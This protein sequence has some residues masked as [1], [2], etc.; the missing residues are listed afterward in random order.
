MKVP[1]QEFI[2]ANAPAIEAIRTESERILTNSIDPMVAER[3]GLAGE[4]VIVAGAYG[5]GDFL[6]RYPHLPD[7]EAQDVAEYVANSRNKV[8]R[9]RAFVKSNGLVARASMDHTI[10]LYEAGL[11]SP[12]DAA[13]REFLD[14]EKSTY[15]LV[16]MLVDDESKVMELGHAQLEGLE[17]YDSADDYDIELTDE[18]GLS[19]QLSIARLGLTVVSVTMD[20]KPQD[21]P[22]ITRCAELLGPGIADIQPL[23]VGRH[24]SAEELDA[25]ISEVWLDYQGTS[26]EQEITPLLDEVR[27]RAIAAKQSHEFVLQHHTNLPTADQLAEFADTLTSS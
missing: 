23:L 6:S 5:T 11:L 3:Q 16:G 24:D 9:H 19:R 12:S 18:F 13:A 10:E 25:A 2:E 21:D 4:T 15:R 7:E 14:Y 17:V 20:A 27:D 1:H 26:K 22:L 8:F